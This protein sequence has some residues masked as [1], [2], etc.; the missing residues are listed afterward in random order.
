MCLVGGVEAIVRK[1][2]YIP[3]IHTEADMGSLARKV[4]S[5]TVQKLGLQQWKSNTHVI[6]QLW[7]RIRQVIEKLDLQWSNVRVYQDG[8]PVSGREMEIVTDLAGK[9]SLNHKLV[10][11]LIKRGATLVGTESP[12]FLLE[13]YT[14][15]Q[16]VL[17]A[18][19][20]AEAARIQDQQKTLSQSL[21]QRRDEFIAG[22]INETLQPGETGILF[23]GLL[24]SVELYLDSDI[25]VSYPILRPATQRTKSSDCTEE[26]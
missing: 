21:L 6:K 20:P 19:D 12:E 24:H 15:I 9:G 11:D 3:V 2:V 26:D 17:A 14:L 4:R 8:L 1:L 10:L 22:R 25:R 18:K 7:D 5:I 16:K 23:L 13:E